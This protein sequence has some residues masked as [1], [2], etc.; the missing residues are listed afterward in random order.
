[1]R[2]NDVSFRF[3]QQKLRDILVTTFSLIFICQQYYI[4]YLIIIVITQPAFMLCLVYISGSCYHF[5][6][7]R[8]QASEVHA[9]AAA[10]Q[11][12]T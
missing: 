6:V 11:T 2:G 9:L 10:I 5:Q 1:M 3:S 12:M 4:I 8:A 7:I